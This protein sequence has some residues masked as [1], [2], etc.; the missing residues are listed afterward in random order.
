MVPLDS[1]ILALQH[2]RDMATDSEQ[3]ALIND[4]ISRLLAE[5]RSNARAL[6]PLFT[7]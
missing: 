7:R 6:P 1:R 4:E 3:I 5:R 2:A